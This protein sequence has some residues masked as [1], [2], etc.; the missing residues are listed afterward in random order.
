LLPGST[1]AT[2]YLRFLSLPRN[3]LRAL[4]GLLLLA[5]AGSTAAAAQDSYPDRFSFLVGGLRQ[6]AGISAGAEY[7]HRHFANGFF[8]LRASTLVSLRLYQRHELQLTFPHVFHSRLFVDVLGLYRSYTQ[9]SYFGV[10]PG[11]QEGDRTDYHID[12]PAIYGSLGL[13]PARGMVIGG[14]IAALDNDLHRGRGS[15]HPS[16][17]EKFTPAELPG[18]L[19]EPDYFQV[20]F[21]A[22]FDRRNDP[23]DPTRGARYELQASRFLARGLDGFDFDEL[24]AEAE[25]YLPVS[26]RATLASRIQTVF[27]GTREGQEVPFFLLP[28]LGGR[29]SLHA[30]SM[31]RFRDRHLLFLNSELRYQAT[32]EIRIS[33][34]VDVGQVFPRAGAIEISGF[35]VG[36]GAAVHYKYGR[37]VL[38]GLSLGLGREGVQVSLDGGFRF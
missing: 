6:G 33:G 24:Q 8:D 15:K 38:V 18:Y 10:G 30:F 31:D 28:S 9:V 26:A 35:E 25:H 21:F 29:E 14:R 1:S 27:T 4:A 17:E 2:V 3:A 36:V 5:A 22:Y 20:G 16:I 23:E 11:T 34:F 12:G 13:R 37:M 7:E 19:Q 32:P